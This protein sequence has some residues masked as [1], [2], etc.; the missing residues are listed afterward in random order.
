MR[1]RII[2]RSDEPSAI[3]PSDDSCGEDRPRRTQTSVSRRAQRLGTAFGQTGGGLEPCGILGPDL[4]DHRT[5]G[6][7]GGGLR[8]GGEGLPGIGRAVQRGAAP[9]AADGCACERQP[10]SSWA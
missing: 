5:V 10:A 2:S 9:A 6:R 3:K 1:W 4:D 7:G 8:L